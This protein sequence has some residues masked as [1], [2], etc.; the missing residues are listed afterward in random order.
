MKKKIEN[1]VMTATKAVYPVAVLTTQAA[2]TA[3]ELAGKIFDD[4]KKAV[5][6]NLRYVPESLDDVTKK[7]SD[8]FFCNLA[9]DYVKNKKALREFMRRSPAWN[10]DLQAWVINGNRTHEPDKNLIK[11]LVEEILCPAMN[12]ENAE[13]I[14]QAMVWFY[15]DSS[16]AGKYLTKLAPKANLRQKKSKVFIAVCKALGVWQDS[17]EFQIKF[18]ALCNEF[19]AKKIDFKLIVSIHPAYFLTMSNPHGKAKYVDGEFKGKFLLLWHKKIPKSG[20][21]I[22]FDERQIFLK[23]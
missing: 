7:A 18:S 21:K 11:K 12:F 13:Y 8:E 17:G 9:W 14:I 19:N 23:K 20:N 22:T 16:I 1:A 6:D 10:E 4:C 15:E 5:A 2:L 3:E